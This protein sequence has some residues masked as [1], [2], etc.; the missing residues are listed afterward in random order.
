MLSGL[1]YELCVYVNVYV[2]CIYVA[3]LLLWNCMFECMCVCECLYARV[4]VFI[5]MLC[6][7]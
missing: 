5:N 3:L 7:C 1:F 4:F 6:V 2:Y